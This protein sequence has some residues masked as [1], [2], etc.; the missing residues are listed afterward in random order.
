V[1]QVERGPPKAHHGIVGIL[2]D[3]TIDAARQLVAEGRASE[4]SGLSVEDST[5]GAAAELACAMLAWQ[6][7]NDSAGLCA[8]EA[9][10]KTAPCLTRAL[11][12]ARGSARPEAER[13]ASPPMEIEPVGADPD[14]LPFLC[15]RFKRSLISHGG[16]SKPLA[17]ALSGALG[18]MADNV[19][20]HSTEKEGEAAPGIVGFA[21]KGPEFE[22]VVA[23]VGRGALA[24]LR[25]I[26]AWEHLTTAK[27]ALDA[28]VTRGATRR[29]GQTQGGGFRDLFT[30]LVDL[31]GELRL[32]SGDAAV[33][34]D[35]RGSPAQRIKVHSAVAPL[36]GFQVTVRGRR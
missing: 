10:A 36:V 25:V 22:F 28:I 34:L 8:G 17:T 33:T 14:E 13:H 26:S 32:R 11:A 12:C 20:R 19:F 9:W 24:S 31:A 35:G 18:E 30:A 16:Y 21:V 29:S 4:L 6:G 27:M 3:D 2:D 23:D 15:E 7:A 1:P 5:L